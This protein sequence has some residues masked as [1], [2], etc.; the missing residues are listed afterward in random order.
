MPD[1]GASRKRQILGRRIP[2]DFSASRS[3]GSK[4][5]PAP[6]GSGVGSRLCCAS[7]EEAA[8]IGDVAR[9]LVNLLLCRFALR[10]DLRRSFA[11]RRSKQLEIMSR[12]TSN[13][14]FR[15]LSSIDVCACFHRGSDDSFRE[16]PAILLRLDSID[17][18]RVDVREGENR[19]ARV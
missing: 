11:D 17:S 14:A 3:I 1:T 15:A 10:R 6:G 5:I 7:R 19:P 16:L 12:Y 13:P 4:T 9:N 18:A 8:R 2:G